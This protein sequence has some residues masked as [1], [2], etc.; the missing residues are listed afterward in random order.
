[1]SHVIPPM[2]HELG[3]HWTQPKLEEVLVDDSHAV[4]TTRSFK[5]LPDYS[6]SYPH[7]RVPGEDV[8]R[9]DARRYVVSAL[10]RHRR[11]QP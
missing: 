4:M 1:M 8:E 9:G 2:T 10:V 3:R 6:R 11:R 7:W 5:K